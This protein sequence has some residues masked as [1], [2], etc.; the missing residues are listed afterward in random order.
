MQTLV[1]EM[2]PTSRFIFQSINAW[3]LYSKHSFSSTLYVNNSQWVVPKHSSWHFIAESGPPCS[4]MMALSSF[5]EMILDPTI[6][7]P[8]S[9]QSPKKIKHHRQ[10]SHKGRNF[11]RIVI[12]VFNDLLQEITIQFLAGL[13]W[14]PWLSPGILI[15][16]IRTCSRFLNNASRRLSFWCFAVIITFISCKMTTRAVS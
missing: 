8:C 10:F 5:F 9:K 3:N 15:V 14:I 12:P 7:T 16:N 11:I 13:H 4:S 6:A 1:P 2:Y